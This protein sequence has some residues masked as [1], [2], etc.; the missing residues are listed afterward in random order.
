MSRKAVVYVLVS[1]LD[2]KPFYV[3]ATIS[4]DVRLSRHIQLA[5]SRV[6][7]NK[8]LNKCQQRIIDVLN[9]G[10]KISLEVIERVC[11]ANNAYRQRRLERRE[12]W[13]IRTLYQWGLPITNEMTPLGYLGKYQWGQPTEVTK[14]TAGLDTYQKK[15]LRFIQSQGGTVQK[16]WGAKYRLC[17]RVL[18][19]KGLLQDEGDHYRTTTL[20]AEVLE[21][22]EK[23]A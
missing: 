22:L 18:C 10:G 3:G 21:L 13:W 11:D 23:G 14:A 7:R 20:A 19:D 8:P 17:A 4:A 5:K 6:R 16:Q 12:D 2:G 15:A 1:S 9:A